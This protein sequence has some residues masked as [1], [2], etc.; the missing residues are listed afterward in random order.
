MFSD[1]LVTQLPSIVVNK[2]CLK[3][4]GIHYCMYTY[5]IYK[6]ANIRVGSVDK[7]V[8]VCLTHHYHVTLF[9]DLVW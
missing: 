7:T 8:V 2:Q 5:V 6:D 3:Q 1:V 4:K 9:D